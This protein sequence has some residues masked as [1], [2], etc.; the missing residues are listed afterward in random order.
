M[1]ITSFQ[2]IIESIEKLSIDEQ[3]YLFELI[4]LLLKPWGFASS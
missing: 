2:E 4:K 1:R 3:E